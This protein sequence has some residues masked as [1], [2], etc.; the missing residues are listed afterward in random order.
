M[1]KLFEKPNYRTDLPVVEIFFT[2]IC[3]TLADMTNLWPGYELISNKFASVTK[4]AFEKQ[5][6]AYI[7]SDDDF[8]VLIHG[9]MWTNNLF[10]KYDE[11]GKPTE[12]KLV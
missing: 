12:I 6:K 7:P 1:F 10:Y 3:K 2:N 4:N 5:Y 9:D 11:N 8:F